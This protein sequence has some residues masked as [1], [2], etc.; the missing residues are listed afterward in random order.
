MNINT[1]LPD[2]TARSLPSEPVFLSLVGKT[3]CSYIILTTVNTQPVR[4]LRSLWLFNQRELKDGLLLFHL[5]RGGRRVRKRGKERGRKWERDRERV[6]WG[7]R[8]WGRDGEVGSR[9]EKKGQ[10]SGRE[11]QTERY[12]DR[13]NEC[14]RA[15]D[16]KRA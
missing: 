11:R 16:E 13:E 3:P 9:R 5:R 8:K 15:R 14:V 12:R 2:N 6:R 4:A 10:V 1:P 7:D